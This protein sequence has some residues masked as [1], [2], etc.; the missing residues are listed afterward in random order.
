MKNQ[1]EFLDIC[2]VQKKI[3]SS[4]Y[5]KYH[6]YYIKNAIF[7]LTL[8]REERDHADLL[9]TITIDPLP[10]NLLEDDIL[11]IKTSIDLMK[12]KHKKCLENQ[13]KIE[14]AYNSVHFFETLAKEFFLEKI[15]ASQT[16]DKHLTM[17]QGIIKEDSIHADKII[18]LIS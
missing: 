15:I 11:N 14:D 3:M 5:F 13:L 6:Q 10:H 1:K 2:I 7:W 18:S 8:A 16:T 12:K 4:L 9:N 17:I